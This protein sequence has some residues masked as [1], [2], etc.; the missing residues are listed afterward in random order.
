MPRFVELPLAGVD[1]KLFLTFKNKPLS[2]RVLVEGK[3]NIKKVTLV[4]D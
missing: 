4:A 2:S 3:C 1:K